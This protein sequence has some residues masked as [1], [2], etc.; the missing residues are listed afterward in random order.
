MLPTT[1]E[2]ITR[3]QAADEFGGHPSFYWRAMREGIK[4]RNGERVRLE[5]ERRGKQLVTSREAIQR[6][7]ERLNAADLEHFTRDDSGATAGDRRALSSE[8]EA[9]GEELARLGV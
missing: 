2:P 4:A 7:R 9:A 8:H 5:H 3:F 1:E 6:H